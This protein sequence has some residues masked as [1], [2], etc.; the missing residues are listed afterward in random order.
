MPGY[1][2]FR[3]SRV[4]NQGG[5]VDRS[6]LR[7]VFVVI[8]FYSHSG[9]FIKPSLQVKVVCSKMQNMQM[10]KKTYP[11]VDGLVR[12]LE[13]YRLKNRIPQQRLADEIGVVFST[14]SRWL[15]GKTKP[16]KI[17]QYHIENFLKKKGL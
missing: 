16:N 3:R 10:Q 1:I 4:P 9:K 8:I 13:Q 12:E 7:G 5:T 15:N 14:V 11:P 2:P 17:Q 6:L